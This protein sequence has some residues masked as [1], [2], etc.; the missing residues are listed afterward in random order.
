MIKWENPQL[1]QTAAI[2]QLQEIVGTL[3]QAETKDADLDYRK[4]SLIH[5][6]FVEED[7]EL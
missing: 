3:V 1:N 7:K 5:D 6:A 2:R 4:M